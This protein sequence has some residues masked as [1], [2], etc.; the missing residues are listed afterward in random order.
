MKFPSALAVAALPL[1]LAAFAANAEQPTLS[2]KGECE[3]FFQGKRLANGAC[4]IKQIGAVVSV[5]AT[6]EENGQLYT[7]IVDNDKNEGV[8]LGCGTFIL[9]R[10]PL[11]SNEATS[12]S[13][14]N[15]YELKVEL[16]QP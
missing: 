2:L 11:K 9:A 10:G 16:E 7:A 5:K 14:P 6:V 1:L 4:E 15:G 12:F 8:I 13:S 3:L